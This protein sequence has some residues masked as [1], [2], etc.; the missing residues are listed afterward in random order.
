MRERVLAIFGALALIA[1]AF[2]VRS[3]IVGGDGGGE[4]GNG[5][6]PV[7]SDSRPVVACTKDLMAMC[8]ALADEG[9]IAA[10]PPPVDLGSVAANTGRVDDVA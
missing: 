10:D 2:V 8:D 9:A 3:L 5:N 1:F 7:S 4:G 6:D